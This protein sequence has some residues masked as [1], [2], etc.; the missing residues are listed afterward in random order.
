M[1]YTCVYPQGHGAG[2]CIT[3]KRLKGYRAH[4]ASWVTGGTHHMVREEE[5]SWRGEAGLGPSPQ[6]SAR[7]KRKC[8]LVRA[9]PGVPLH[10]TQAV[11]EPRSHLQGLPQPLWGPPPERE[12]QNQ[13]IRGSYCVT[14]AKQS[15]AYLPASE[16]PAY[17][18]WSPGDRKHHRHGAE[19]P[20]KSC[21]QPPR[22]GDGRA[23]ALGASG[24]RAS[25]HTCLAALL[26][27]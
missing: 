26:S 24:K 18:L 1:A 11:V 13:C 16:S 12:G 22:P 19:K 6:H 2:A 20:P 27:C 15:S 5:G 8:S 23:P 14:E 7:G 21:P 10:A 9:L 4:R 17:R 25:K 3:Q